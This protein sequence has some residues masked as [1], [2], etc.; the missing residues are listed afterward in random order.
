MLVKDNQ[1]THAI[2]QPRFEA[3]TIEKFTRCNG[4][5]HLVLMLSA[6]FA[7]PCPAICRMELGL[8]SG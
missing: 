1:D 4:S 3:Q 5:V 7:A 6:G 8:G 2:S